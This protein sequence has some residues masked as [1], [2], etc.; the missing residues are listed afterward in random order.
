MKLLH[1]ALAACRKLE[2]CLIR[3][4][5]D[6]EAVP[7]YG[8]T[9]LTP[10]KIP[11]TPSNEY[12]RALKFALSQKS[13][14]N[15]AVTGSYGAGKSTVINSYV[16][17]YEK[18][19]FIN[20]SLAGFDMPGN[21]DPAKS[22]EVELSIL[23]QILYKKNRDA[24]PDSRID[25]ILNRNKAHICR[26]F[27]ASLK[28]LLPLCGILFLLFNEKVS[29]SAGIPDYIYNTINSLP[30]GKMAALFILSII[31]LYYIVESASKVG[32]FDK[33]IKL[34]KVGL[35][36]GEMELDSTESS[37]L[38][39][40]CLDE[41]VYFFSKIEEYRIVI[42]E[43]LDRLKN[44][45]IFVKLREIN[46]IVNNN[47]SEDK[48]LRFIYAVRDDI[49]SGAASRTKF[50][51]FIVP[52]VPVMDS[53]NAFSLL[54]TRMS[55]MIPG[56]EECLRSTATYISDMRM[57]QNIVN[58]YRIFSAM[59]DNNNRKVSLYA[60]VFYKNIFAHDYSLIERNISL[61]YR[62]VY[63]YRTQKLHEQYFTGLNDRIDSLSRKLAEIRREKSN[64]AEEVRRDLISIYLPDK[65]KGMVY[66]YK[67]P[68]TVGFNQPGTEQP[69]TNLLISDEFVFENFFS[70]TGISIGYISQN[71][72]ITEKLTDAERTSLFDTY[73]RRKEL[74][75]EERERNFIRV[76]AELKQALEDKRRRNAISLAELVKL[77]QKD[78]FDA[79]A[80][81]YMDDID[82]HDFLSADH[83]KA[84]RDEMRYGGSD[85]LYLLLSRGYLDQDFMRSRSVFHDGGLSVNDNEF[86]KNV[87][88]GLSAIRSNEDIALDDVSGVILEIGA[89]HLLHHDASLH[90]QIVAHM[91]KTGD[92]RL[93]EMLATLFTK[94][95]K[96]VLDLMV[97]LE[98]RF[99]EPDIFVSLLVKALDKNPYL[100]VMVA[101]L[102]EAGSGRSY[103]RIAAAVISNI[104]PDRAENR[105]D[106][107][108]YVKSLGS[109]IA[110]FL[111]PE[112]IQ[113]FMTHIASLEVRYERLSVPIS[114]AEKECVRFIGENSLYLLTGENVGIALAVQ[115]SDSQATT[116][117]CRA[118]PWTT[119]QVHAL[120][121]LAYFKE[122]ADEFVESVFL[123]SQEQGQA[124]TDVLALEALSDEMKFR[125]VGE[126]N[127]CLD[128]LSGI[129]DLPARTDVTPQ[130]SFHDLFYHH[131]RI[132]AG[133]P[134]LLSFISEDCNMQVLTS[135]MARH[136]G[137]L[138]L[139]GPEVSDGDVYS[140]LYKKVICNAEFSN[141]DYRKIMTHVEI[142]TSFF[143]DSMD[144][145]QLI[146]LLEMNKIT[147]S[148]ENFTNVIKNASLTDPKFTL[149]LADWFSRHQDIFLTAI[150]LYLQR[151]SCEEVFPILLG[152]VMHSPLLSDDIK[153]ELYNHYEE[154]YLVGDEA[155]IDLPQEI[156]ASAFMVSNNQE[157]KMRLMTSLI[158]KNFRDKKV[159]A[160]MTGRMSERELKK[161]FTHKGE[162][163]LTLIDRDLCVPLLDALRKAALIKDYEFRDDGKVFVIIQRSVNEDDE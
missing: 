33:K 13:V 20:V 88:L 35:L 57:L 65:L 56:G 11:I 143:D 59:V 99:A 107:R 28:I 149:A 137:T 27:L 105:S 26:V 62:F 22:Q 25:R 92:E 147:L 69:D 86:I 109:G 52:V 42:F 119:A 85:A 161:I 115:L 74:V 134:E 126:M 73:Q 132:Q 24:L 51:D 4:L 9:A 91:L 16:E 135:F 15:I 129:S 148:E 67:Q 98:S 162:A 66:F 97:T 34:N 18:G 14:R 87:A 60:M 44:P 160:E 54:N 127:F 154:D 10:K 12:F 157:M 142:N 19:H 151:E 72:Y 84:V 78:K 112:E 93:N 71:R 61:L 31:T 114:D 48:P 83:K 124:V 30:Y 55:E 77:L 101:H 140:L 156:K 141:E 130:L 58:E 117:E 46:K 138:S 53:R 110:D 81:Q 90:H 106:Y 6:E 2:T 102:N 155:D 123:S 1:W 113:S 41:I 122:N 128:S 82:T 43:D 75:G 38:L 95:G 152:R 5:P 80:S 89:Q 145:V 125:I 3:L 150:D 8:F 64:T 76:Q 70:S 32:V 21:G 79:I 37:S 68:P 159:L 118:L 94:S 116:E 108:R 29:Q 49:F 144:N 139:S 120:S 47:L 39:N 153:M 36:S 103:L 163:T 121:A 158:A 17:E 111:E 23:Q 131:N 50:F 104:E 146:R 63:Q 133:W 45:E 40:N 100:D 7:D 96:H 136:A